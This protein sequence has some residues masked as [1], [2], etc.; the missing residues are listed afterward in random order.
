LFAKLGGFLG[1]VALTTAQKNVVMIIV[2]DLRPM[3]KGWDESAFQNMVTPHL[4]SLVKDSLILR[5]SH[6]QQAECGPSRASVLTGRRPDTTHIYELSTYFRDA[7]CATCVTIPGA[8]KNAGYRTFGLGKVFHPLASSGYDNDGNYSWSEPYYEPPDEWCNKDSGGC[9]NAN[10]NQCK[11]DDEVM[12]AS[13]SWEAV[14]E[15]DPELGYLTDTLVAMQFNATLDA[16]YPPIPTETPHRT[17]DLAGDGDPPPWFAAVG[18]HKPHLPFIV[19]RE[20]F[21]L[22]PLD[23]DDGGD[24]LV[25]LATNP[26]APAYMPTVAYASWELESWGDV[27]ATGC[28]EACV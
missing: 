20:F 6:V 8:F 13:L 15:P 16:L 25:P 12:A 23:G 22:Y 26:Y 27:S 17:D 1:F 4:D 9:M 28:R 24:D 10:G 21:D 11:D 7:G 18:F 19:P 5:E 2:D 14:E 3:I